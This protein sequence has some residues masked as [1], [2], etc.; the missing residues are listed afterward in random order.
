M[1]TATEGPKRAKWR[2]AR[3][4]RGRGKEAS[5]QLDSSSHPDRSKLVGVLYERDV[6]VGL[7][8]KH[9]KS[10]EISMAMDE[11]S[12]HSQEEVEARVLTEVLEHT[13]SDREHRKTGFAYL[14]K[15][16]KQLACRKTSQRSAHAAREGRRGTGRT[17]KGS[18][19]SSCNTS[20]PLMRR[21]RR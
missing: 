15:I 6:V 18:V 3:G 20:P 16:L 8:C 10:H 4:K 5:S 14:I 19:P 12:L 9:R 21:R 13:A 2:Q 7:T 11:S 1:T 17:N